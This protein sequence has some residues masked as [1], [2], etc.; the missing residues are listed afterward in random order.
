MPHSTLETPTVS[1]DEAQNVS[2]EPGDPTKWSPRP[3]NV[4]RAL[5]CLGALATTHVVG[6]ASAAD[7]CVPSFDGVT[8]KLL[9]DPGVL[10]LQGHAA[11]VNR[12][13]IAGGPTGVGPVIIA[14]GSDPN[15]DL[16][17][18]GQGAGVVRAYD[19]GIYREVATIS[20][21]QTLTNKTLT[22]PKIAAIH[23]PTENTKVLE[24]VGAAG[25]DNFLKITNANG[26]E[27]KLESAGGNGMIL[28]DTGEDAYF[29]ISNHL[30][31]YHGNIGITCDGST[32]V[33]Y[34]QLTCATYHNTASMQS[35]FN[36]YRGRGTISGKL[37]VQNGDAI[38]VFNFAGYSSGWKERASLGC[39]VD[40]VVSGTTV[41]LAL[42]FCT[43]TTAKTERL[44]IASD[45]HGLWAA[46]RRCEFRDAAQYICSPAAN[47][48]DIAAGQY[49]H[50]DCGLG[51]RFYDDGVIQA[52]IEEDHFYLY[53]GGSS[54][55]FDI[56][57]ASTL[58]LK[59][60]AASRITIN[61]T[62]IGFNGRTPIARPDY[63][64]ANSATVRSYDCTTHGIE[65]LE[66]LVCTLI[67][68]L[69]NYGILQ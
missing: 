16:D 5:D 13:R 14:A 43:G 64:T 68:D 67:E 42:I 10:K 55:D 17:L 31:G 48:L 51:I 41:P 63:T 8:G 56:A 65:E 26:A 12:V 37:A 27:I 25:A 9:Q 15:I 61:G 57:T 59:V 4:R 28:Q 3:R 54:I 44:R 19:S 21:A 40:G 24:L 2:Y 32:A 22:A 62:G 53:P 47:R 52:K 38:G 20:G 34:S 29:K 50:L 18:A 11:Y 46:D 66:D 58:D 30:W 45:G 1:L 23:D 60:G 39:E 7:E 49:I 36:V 33:N 35:K 69:I 6:P